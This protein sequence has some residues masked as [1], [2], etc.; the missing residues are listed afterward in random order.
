MP[1]PRYIEVEGDRP[2]VER[3]RH[4]FSAIVA[5]LRTAEEYLMQVERDGVRYANALA[6]IA[7]VCE[8]EPDAVSAATTAADIARDALAD[9]PSTTDAVQTDRSTTRQ[10]SPR[11]GSG[12][13]RPRARGFVND[14]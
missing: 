4:H 9:T 10:P 6:R 2:K 8:N 3:T 5:G 11:S 14:G 12:K 13:S 7:E 1:K